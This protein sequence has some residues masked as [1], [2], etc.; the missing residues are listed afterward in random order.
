MSRRKCFCC[1]CTATVIITVK[2]CN[3]VLQSGASVSATDGT[4]TL[5]PG[6]TN[7]SGVVSFT[8]PN[9]GT[10][11]FTAS[12]T[13]TTTAATISVVT[14]GATYGRTIC[15]GAGILKVQ[16]AGCDGSYSG[17]NIRFTQ[18]GSTIG[19]VTTDGAGNA[20]LCLPSI[21]SAV[22]ATVT[23]TPV[24][25][26]SASVTVSSFVACGTK[27][28]S[29]TMPT[30]SGYIC[31]CTFG[32]SPCGTAPPATL[33][34][35]LLSPYSGSTITLNT[36]ATYGGVS[37]TETVTLSGTCS[38]ALYTEPVVVTYYYM[39]THP[40]SSCGGTG[41]EFV[42]TFAPTI[43]TACPGSATACLTATACPPSYYASG[44]YGTGGGPPGP[45][46]TVFQ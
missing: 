7:G 11:T 21:A 35:Y 25:Y 23:P 22:T 34:L 12:G 40:S 13:G 44:T 32:V 15:L 36:D 6:T 14:C 46:F 42:I 16:L 26:G 28:V 43:H 17:A 29:L 24:G 8:V 38:G 3:G 37:G 5:T 18:G 39:G 45:T 4:T 9:L 27:T 30:A 31:V 19:N 2:G 1:S 41:C 20:S 10:W 33:P